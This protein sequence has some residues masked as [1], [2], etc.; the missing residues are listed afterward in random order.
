M[1]NK[2]QLFFNGEV[3]DTEASKRSGLSGAVVYRRKDGKGLI[4]SL[5]SF[6][7]ILQADMIGIF[8]AA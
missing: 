6:T 5:G 8:A 2:I 3:W 4:L 7:T 1:I